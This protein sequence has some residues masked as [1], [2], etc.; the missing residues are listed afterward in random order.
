M[1]V[2]TFLGGPAEVK[3]TVAYAVTVRAVAI[4][5]N[6][7]AVITHS[8]NELPSVFTNRSANIADPPHR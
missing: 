5:H 6:G 8:Q 3:R 2:R 7:D 1:T 4:G